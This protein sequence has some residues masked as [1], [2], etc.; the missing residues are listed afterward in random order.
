ML[1]SGN[2]SATWFVSVLA[3]TQGADNGWALARIRW[4]I[5][6]GGLAF[7]WNGQAL[8]F[9][10]SVNNDYVNKALS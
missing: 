9:W 1:S 2:I 7:C 10:A 4:Q 3:W 6:R 5:Q 8:L